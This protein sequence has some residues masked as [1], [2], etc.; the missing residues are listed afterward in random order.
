[1]RANAEAIEALPPHGT[2]IVPAGAPE[3]ARHLTRDDVDV[4]TFAPTDA[5][6]RG[7][8]RWRFRVT[9]EEVE[10]RLPFR[11]RHLAE[12]TL[13]ALLAYHVLGLPLERAQEGIDGIVLSRWRG[14]EVPLAGG[15]VAI[16]DAYN[17]N[18]TSMR[19]ALLDLAERA[20]GRRRVAVLGEMAELGAESER[21]HRE[22]GALIDELGIEAVVGVGRLG[23]LYLEPGG[24]ADL[25][26]V[27]T[28]EELPDLLGDVVHAGDVVLVKASRA[29][30]LEGI[31]EQI[32]K[33]AGTW[34][35]S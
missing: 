17:A 34:S 21:Y 27:E 22:I 12:N 25:R 2:A 9:G 11:Q 10:L 35:E 32:A 16:N 4:Q 18:P 19:A 30:G 20:D 7:G 24:G 31:P 6:R 15:G 14:E 8:D 5:E 29:V 3:L 13:A 33:L 1:V 26:W 28:V 23:R